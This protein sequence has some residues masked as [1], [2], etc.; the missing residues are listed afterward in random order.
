[1]F[2]KLSGSITRIGSFGIGATIDANLETGFGDVGG[3][4]FSS[5]AFSIDA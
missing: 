5:S 4:V 1:M 3:I 2:L